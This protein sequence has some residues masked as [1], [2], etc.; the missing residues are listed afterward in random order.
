MNLYFVLSQ[1]YLPY[2]T[3]LL[4]DGS[5]PTDREPICELVVARNRSQARWLA[6]QRA[7]WSITDVRDM[8]AFAVYGVLRNVPGPARIASTEY[9]EP[10]LWRA[11]LE[12]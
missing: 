2:E 6:A 3:A 5:G 1:E 7:P 10:E 9:T 4:E 8:P 11:A 12:G